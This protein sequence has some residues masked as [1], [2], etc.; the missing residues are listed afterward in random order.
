VS[1]PAPIDLAAWQ[2]MTAKQDLEKAR[3]HL[4]ECE[5]AVIELVG[6]KPEGTQVQK[7]PYFK[8][9]TVQSLTRSLTPD[10]EALIEAE[11][12]PIFD[13][14][15]RYRPEVSVTGL[16]SLA[17]SNPAVYA[18]VIKAIITKPGKPS[19]KVELLEEAA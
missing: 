13:Q 17:T 7:T 6:L 4:I 15:V 10:G 18:R 14:I 19:V 5:Q 9:S 8:V 3:Q 12:I 2:L 16:K 11:G 1:Q